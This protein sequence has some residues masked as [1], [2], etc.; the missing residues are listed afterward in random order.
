MSYSVGNLVVMIRKLLLSASVLLL[1][2]L[3]G[4]K[5][6][7]EEALALPSAIIDFGEMGTSIQV[8]ETI[9]FTLKATFPAGLKSATSNIWVDDQIIEMVLDQGRD[10]LSFSFENTYTFE[11]TP[12]Y[13]GNSIVF[14]F[15]V[16][17]LLDNTAGDTIA[18]TVDESA[19]SLIENKSLSSFNS[20]N[21]GSFYDISQDTSYF[22]VNVRNSTALKRTIDLLFFYT[23]NDKAVISAPSNDFSELSWSNQSNALW[24]LFGVEN[25]TKFYDLGTAIN[26]NDIITGA[27]VATLIS[28]QPAS[29]DSLVDIQNGQ[30]IGIE[31]A[32]SRGSKQGIIKV[33]T[34][35][36]NSIS[37]TKITFDAKL[38]R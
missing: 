10:S 9:S 22:G 6:D 28:A 3:T 5:K 26:F 8:L 32:S 18:L 1:I 25:D 23:V 38:Q 37:N 36:G 4:C 27:Q 2:V 13:A 31:L 15:S 30:Y 17:D 33:N 29:L 19:L 11:V 7:S 16:T 24:P 35:E 20:A 34:V 21:F 12:Q 14:T